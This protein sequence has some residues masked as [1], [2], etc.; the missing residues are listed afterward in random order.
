LPIIV[1]ANETIVLNNGKRIETTYIWKSKGKI[2][3]FS[4]GKEL[5]FDKDE[6]KEIL[7]PEIK[8]DSEVTYNESSTVESKRKINEQSRAENPVSSVPKTRA[9]NDIKKR[10]AETYPG[11]FSTQK[12][13]LDANMEAYD[14]LSR[15]P[16]TAVT[17]L[18]LSNL[19]SRYYPNFSA[20]EMLY[21]SNIKAYEDLQSY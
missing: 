20:I 18:I 3:C 6:I 15:L 5:S 14:R 17:N 12:M 8:I 4:K 19:K 7:K 13:L 11:H 1:F 9:L 21:K 2:N 16:A 10:L